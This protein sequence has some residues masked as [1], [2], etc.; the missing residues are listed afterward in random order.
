MSVTLKEIAARLNVSTS[1]VSGVLN[2]RS[3]IWASEENRR[4]IIA[5]AEEL[6]YRPH[7]MARALGSGKSL[8]VAYVTLHG[9]ST[10]SSPSSVSGT[11]AEKL[12]ASGYQLLIQS[13]S[14][15]PELLQLLKDLVQDRR[16]DAVVLWGDEEEVEEQGMF[17]E[18]RGIPFVVKGRHEERHPDWPQI[19]FDHEAM[20]A[21]AVRSLHSLGHTRIAYMGFFLSRVYRHR[22]LDGYRREMETLGVPLE[23]AWIAE[24]NGSLPS[25]FRQMENWLSLPPETRPTAVVLS[26]GDY[27]WRGMELA[28]AKAGLRCGDA[29]G[30]F[31]AMGSGSPGLHLLFGQ[32][33]AYQELELHHLA[34]TMVD[35]L[36]IP[37]LKRLPTEENV[38]RLMPELRPLPS[39][40]LNLD[41]A[42]E[43]QPPD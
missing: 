3:G 8:T 37:L 26:A 14:T 4:R 21:Q 16:C 1:L 43:Y 39:L 13:S 6:G 20:N 18:A 15:Q 32:G 42:R 27:A 7:A 34:H 25:A 40:G 17:L 9:A 12:S 36:L 30:E 10:H 41:G 11:L 31:G 35:R 24:G 5:M 28:L 29:P 38:I 19:E 33:R 22:L 2:E 23:E